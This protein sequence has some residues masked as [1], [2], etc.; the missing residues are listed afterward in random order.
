MNKNTEYIIK[1]EQPDG[2]NPS[3]VLQQLPSPISRDMKEIYNYSVESDGFYIFDRNV[4]STVV[5]YAIKLFLD[6]A[7]QYSDSVEIIKK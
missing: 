3:S 5:G 1:W 7:L 2:Y 6:E 4:D